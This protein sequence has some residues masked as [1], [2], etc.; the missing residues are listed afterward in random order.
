MKENKIAGF[1]LFSGFHP[2]LPR[3]CTVCVMMCDFSCGSA[4]F[5]DWKKRKAPLPPWHWTDEQIRGLMRRHNIIS[6]SCVFC[7][8]SC[9]MCC[10]LYEQSKTIATLCYPLTDILTDC[11]NLGTTNACNSCKYRCTVRE[12]ANT[13][14][15]NSHHYRHT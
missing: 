6:P 1:S 10:T 15:M 9:N 11:E 3:V 2:F 8:P 12:R 4:A 13:T 5:S 7:T 14:M